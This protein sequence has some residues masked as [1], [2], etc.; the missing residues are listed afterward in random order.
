[1]ISK[2]VIAL[3]VSQHFNAVFPQLKGVADLLVVRDFGRLPGMREDYL[4]KVYHT[5]GLVNIE[6]AEEMNG[7]FLENINKNNIKHISFDLGP[8]CLDVKFNPQE[9]DCFWPNNSSPTLGEHEIL[10]V[11]TERLKN[12]RQVFNGSI[13]LE[14][15]DYH[16]GGAYEHVCEAGFICDALNKLGCYLALDIAHLLVS[17]FNF[18]ID[19][20]TYISMLPL[21]LIKEIHLSHPQGNFDAHS[22]PTDNEYKL[23]EFLLSKSNPDFI[24]IEY[25]DQPEVIIKENKRLHEFLNRDK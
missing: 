17:C 15:L 1:M 3:P 13:A 9:H 11:A 22:A 14:N 5:N 16:K 6:F 20:F 25:Y 10:E 2:P 21:D 23:L 7:K 8:S 19:Q 24:V 18:G 12:I 4:P